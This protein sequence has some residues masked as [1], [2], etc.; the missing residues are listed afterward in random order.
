MDFE[1]FKLLAIGGHLALLVGSLVFPRL[2]V[3]AGLLCLGLCLAVVM[4]GIW[5]GSQG[6]D[7]DLLEI[8][9]SFVLIGGIGIAEVVWGHNTAGR[10]PVRSRG[11]VT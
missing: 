3:P 9:P 7:A 1:T 5:A 10:Q 6:R 11:R 4:A 2:R 8:W